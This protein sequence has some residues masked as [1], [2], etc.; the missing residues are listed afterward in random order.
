MRASKRP[1]PLLTRCRAPSTCD[2]PGKLAVWVAS[3]EGKDALLGSGPEV[4]S[5]I[6]HH[7]GRPIV[8]VDLAA[9]D[10]DEADELITDLWRLRA[11]KRAAAAGGPEPTAPGDRRT[12]LLGA[13]V[14]CQPMR[15]G[16]GPPRPASPRSRPSMV[17]TSSSDSSKSNTSRF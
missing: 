1:Q 15:S 7:D 10:P 4:F 8:F 17:A 14:G 9:V 5:T 2:E 3:L 13:A 11:P 16:C 6:P 12:D